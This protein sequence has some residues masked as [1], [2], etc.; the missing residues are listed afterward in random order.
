[1]MTGPVMQLAVGKARP[2]TLVT[3]ASAH[4]RRVHG[5]AGTIDAMKNRLNCL[6]GAIVGVAVVGRAVRALVAQRT[7]RGVAESAS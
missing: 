5:G 1:M 6:T 3:T 7:S 2:A 4:P